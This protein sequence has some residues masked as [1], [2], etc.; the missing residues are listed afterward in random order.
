M[1]VIEHVPDDVALMSDLARRFLKPGGHMVVSVPAWPTL[2][3]KHDVALKHFRR[4][5]PAMGRRAIE[6]SGLA[7]V[8]SG[9][10]FHALAAV[11]R[12]QV[13]RWGRAEPAA[14]PLATTPEDDGG[15]VGLGAWKGSP[16]VTRAVAGVLN[17][18]GLVSW[19]AS[20]AGVGLPGLSW[21][22]LARKD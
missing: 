1:D 9:G 17:A 8:R 2:F 6:A 13:A 12:L 20:A 14:D 19:A 21:W 4:Y 18:E 7:I 5:T 22:A 3:S 10:L 16:A 15:G 11:R